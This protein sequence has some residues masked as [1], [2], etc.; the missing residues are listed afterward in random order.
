MNIAWSRLLTFLLFSGMLYGL[1]DG[2]S[3][4]RSP[5]LHGG[6]RKRFPVVI[7]YYLLVW[8]CIFGIVG[9]LGL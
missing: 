7:V 4:D 5:R 2:L 6:W 1:M 3:R 8:F 9:A